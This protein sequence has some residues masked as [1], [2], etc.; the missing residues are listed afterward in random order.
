MT[1]ILQKISFSEID[2][3]RSANL[4]YGIKSNILNP[5]EVSDLLQVKPT[6]AISKGEKYSI[7]RRNQNKNQINEIWETSSIGIWYFE[8]MN[9]IHSLIIEDHVNYLLS[10]LIPKKEGLNKYL[11]NVNEYE[12]GIHIYWEPRDN[13]GSYEV[14]SELIH[15]LSEYCHYFEFSFSS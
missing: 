9:N 13:W 14:K 10:I 11:S 6:R 15:E 4:I 12:V 8:T 7:K 2:N 1:R 5:Q 3:T